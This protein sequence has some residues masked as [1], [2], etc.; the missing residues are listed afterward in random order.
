[1]AQATSPPTG[2]DADDERPTG[3]ETAEIEALVKIMPLALDRLLGSRGESPGGRHATRGK[4]ETTS[5]NQGGNAVL[6]FLRHCLP[7]ASV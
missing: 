6:A 2:Y 4:N 7:L 5:H 3:A 1:M